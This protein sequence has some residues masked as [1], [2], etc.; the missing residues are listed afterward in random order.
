M[1]TTSA[2]LEWQP[3]SFTYVQ[4]AMEEWC[5]AACVTMA[6]TDVLG[7]RLRQCD[8][9]CKTL[10][11]DDCCNEP[12]PQRCNTEL[13]IELVANAYE[14]LGLRATFRSGCPS[15]GDLAAALAG[16]GVVQ[17]LYQWNTGDAHVAIVYDFDQRSGLFAVADPAPKLGM[18]TVQYDDIAE[19]YSRGRCAGAW[20]GIGRA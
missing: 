3:R 9:V 6:A 5:W 7:A 11:F 18:G 14:R 2:L 8:A 13:N 12:P 1:A 10:G 15:S 17:V 16:R 4:Q 20:T 19:A